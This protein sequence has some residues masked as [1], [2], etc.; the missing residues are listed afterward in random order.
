MI[1]VR[2]AGNLLFFD[3]KEVRDMGCNM[4][5][6][7]HF[8]QIQCIGVSP[9]GT[10]V[11]SADRAGIVAV[12]HPL[13]ELYHQRIWRN[14]KQEFV[15][16]TAIAVNDTGKCMA[17][18][19][20]LQVAVYGLYQSWEYTALGKATIPLKKPI[21]SLE[22]TDNDHVIC[23]DQESNEVILAAENGWRPKV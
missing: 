16:A 18:V 19:I 11:I 15:G 1:S 6:P 23:R 20:G 2:F 8:E 9:Q 10:H 21:T 3:D 13:R 14:C 12:W 17:I 7:A 22:F 5:V 4:E